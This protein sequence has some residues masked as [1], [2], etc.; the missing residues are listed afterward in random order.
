MRLQDRADGPS[1]AD[2]GR[3]PAL[4]A[5]PEGRV[6]APEHGDAGELPSTLCLQSPGSKHLAL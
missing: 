5:G 2:P 3:V 6:R 1:V 4:G